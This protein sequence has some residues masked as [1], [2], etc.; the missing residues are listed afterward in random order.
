MELIF[1]C[2]EWDLNLPP[3]YKASGHN[4][5]TMETVSFR[6]GSNFRSSKYCVRFSFN[7]LNSQH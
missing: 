7:T 2:P 4:H 6:S 1:I 3:P 5:Y